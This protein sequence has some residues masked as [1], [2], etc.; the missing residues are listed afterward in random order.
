MENNIASG[1]IMKYLTKIS[2]KKFNITL[3][4]IGEKLDVDVDGET[5]PVEF[6]RIGGTNIYSFLLNNK[7]YD[8][9]LYKNETGYMVH[10]RGSNYKCYVED[11]HLAKYK[12]SI[13]KKSKSQSINEIKSPM[14]GLVV[15][16]EVEVGQKVKAGQGIAI[17]EAMKMENEIKA[18]SDAVV[19]EIKVSLKQAVEMNQTLVVFQ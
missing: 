10:H 4:D 3:Q 1:I 16:I 11:E 14:P 7:S 9:E 2:K 13:K 18:R 15:A 19:K 5:L 12:N 8:I 17:I 6:I